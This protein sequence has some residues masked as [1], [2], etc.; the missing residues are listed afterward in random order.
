MSGKRK[1]QR[2]TSGEA[3]IFMV[4][5]IAA[6]SLLIAGCTEW[7]SSAGLRGSRGDGAASVVSDAEIARTIARIRPVRGNAKSHLL[8]AKHYRYLHEEEGLELK[9]AILQG[10]MERLVPI[11]M[12]ALTTIMGSV[13][14]ILASG[15]G[16]E[17]RLV[18]GVVVFFGVGLATFLTL[19]IV[20]VAYQVF[21]RGTGSPERARQELEIELARS[22]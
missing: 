7:K 6:V 15:A 9:Q 22:E 13:P 10:S 21:A 14:L 8:L 3:A 20:P 12:T 4:L 16:S 5:V 2:V 17:A 18:I 11:L 19:F 1:R